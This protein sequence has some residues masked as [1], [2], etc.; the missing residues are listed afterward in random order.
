MVINAIIELYHC[1]VTALK[2]NSDKTSDIIVDIVA[3][4]YFNKGNKV[5]EAIRLVFIP[6]QFEH[7]EANFHLKMTNGNNEYELL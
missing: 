4:S 6:P 5:H 7:A 2:N 1:D 3:S